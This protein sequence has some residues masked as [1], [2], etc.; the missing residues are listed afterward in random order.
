LLNIPRRHPARH[1]DL[2]VGDHACDIL[3]R[4]RV[5]VRLLCTAAMVGTQ[6]MAAA[7]RI[8]VRIGSSRRAASW[9]RSGVFARLRTNI[10]LTSKAGPPSKDRPSAPR[11][12]SAHPA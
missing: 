5:A 10:N 2:R 8:T 6:R 1:G 3:V 11:R 12:R 7:A 4:Q 9:L